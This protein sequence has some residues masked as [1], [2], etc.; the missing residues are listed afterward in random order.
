MHTE[1]CSK[2]ENTN[3][4]ANPKVRKTQ[5]SDLPAGRFEVDCAPPGGHSA[6]HPHEEVSFGAH[7]FAFLVK[8]LP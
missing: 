3:L 2:E 5:L 7:L 6:F 4:G 8:A 1:H